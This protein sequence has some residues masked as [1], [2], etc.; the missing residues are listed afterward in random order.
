MKPIAD[1]VVSERYDALCEYNTKMTDMYHSH[2][3]QMIA[4]K[5]ARREEIAQLLSDE[6]KQ[7]EIDNKWINDF[8][9]QIEDLGRR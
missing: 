6:E 8:A 2:L 5:I 7:L 1:E 3:Q 4:D 9:E